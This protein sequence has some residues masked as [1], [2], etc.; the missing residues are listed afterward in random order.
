MEM[1]QSCADDFC[2]TCA[3]ALLT[4]TVLSLCTETEIALV[5]LDGRQEE[6]DISLLEHVEPGDTLLIHGGVAL[7]RQA[8]DEAETS[9]ETA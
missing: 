1:R 5:E 8:S 4:A 2:L 9:E 3:D 6:V 7:A